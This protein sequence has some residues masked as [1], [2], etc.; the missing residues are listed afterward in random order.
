[1][2]WNQLTFSEVIFENREIEAYT[3]IQ[4]PDFCEKWARRE[5]ASEKYIILLK[6][7]KLIC[8]TW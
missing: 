3:K 7:K 5:E 6:K 2:C 1:M 8:D 4:K